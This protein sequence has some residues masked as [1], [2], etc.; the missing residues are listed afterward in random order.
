MTRESSIDLHTGFRDP[1]RADPADVAGFLH[2]VDRL[3]GVR[4]VRRLMRAE[5]ALQP[6]MTLVDAGCGLGLET[7]R[8]A[9]RAPEVRVVGVDHNPA[10]LASAYRQAA[11]R[12][13][14]PE[15]VCADLAESGLPP[16]SVDVVRTERVLMYV[17]DLESAV[18]GLV[19]LLRPGG[20][21]VAFELDYGGTL[22]AP[23]R[24]PAAVVRRIE[25]CLE[26]SLP[27]PW[28][29]RML[30]GLLERHGLTVSAR[31]YSF[32]VDG[33]IWR[34]IV[35]DTVRQAVQDGT[36]AGREIMEWLD[37][38]ADEA[39]PGFRAAFTGVLTVA[40]RQPRAA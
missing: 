9:A 3:P 16:A 22:L 21:I 39:F 31:P 38:L 12:T 18:S 7:T 33:I 4:A 13:P 20:R 5:L 15:W 34:R 30:P 17:P 35:H 37:E 6:G 28:A 1:K 27:Q 40:V 8:L 29:G 2:A 14:E 10:L 24:Q 11:A 26:R 25:A 19:R 23:G 32:P 36:L